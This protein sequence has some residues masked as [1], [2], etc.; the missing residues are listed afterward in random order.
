M[1]PFQLWR[2]ETFEAKRNRVVPVCI[3]T[4]AQQAQDLL[5]ATVLCIDDQEEALAIRQLLLETKGHCVLTGSTLEAA[6]QL[7][8]ADTVDV[9]V[10]DYRLVG[11]SGEEVAR[12]L[13]RSKPDLPIILLS[14][15]PEVPESA[16]A[17]VDRFVVKGESPQVL[18][19]AIDSVLGIPSPQRGGHNEAV[20]DVS[21]KLVQRSQQLLD[22]SATL[23]EKLRRNLHSR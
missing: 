18:L 9:V 21:R 7:T 12:E 20:A 6:L 16:L 19:D 13:K 23:Q 10:L 15:Y 4:T 11:V 8:R 5:M 17:T 22:E 14:G 2:A 1:P 3:Q